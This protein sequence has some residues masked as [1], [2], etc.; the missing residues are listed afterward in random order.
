MADELTVVIDTMTGTFLVEGPDR[1]P[2][3]LRD[4]LEGL[5][6]PARTIACA[7]PTEG[8]T[9]MPASTDELTAVT[10]SVSPAS[11]TAA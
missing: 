3:E 4:A 8:Q 1:L 9:L 11:G 5:G 6:G 10:A 2:R 7:A